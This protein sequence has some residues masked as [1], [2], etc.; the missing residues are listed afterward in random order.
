[1]PFLFVLHTFVLMNNILEGQ[2]H[3]G[4]VKWTY[5]GEIDRVTSCNCSV[6]G[7]YGTLWAYGYRDKN[8]KVSGETTA[9]YR[10]DKELG[11][12]FCPNCG[13]VAYWLAVNER[14]EGLRI[15][16]NTRLI[17]KPEA[18]QDIPIRHFD[19]LDKFEEDP[20]DEKTVKDLWY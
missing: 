7:K 4:Q 12:H 5:E 11:F 10:G 18:I 13:C 2:C 19:G 20:R 3:C 14:K 8:V 1:M 15:A 9:Y 17:N 16:V 6:C